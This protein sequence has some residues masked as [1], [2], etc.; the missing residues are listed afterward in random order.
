MSG[1]LEDNLEGGLE[2][3]DLLLPPIDESDFF[4]EE[5]VKE[6]WAGA[7][8]R[9]AVPAGGAPAAG[10]ARGAPVDLDGGDSDGPDVDLDVDLDDL[11]GD[12]DGAEDD[13][14][15]SPGGEGGK[16]R[17]P[18]RGNKSGI[19]TKGASS[20]AD[21]KRMRRKQI[22]SA[23]RASRARR[24]QELEDLREENKKLRAERA[25]FLN[26]IG[27]LQVKVENMRERGSSDMRVENALLRAQLEEHKRFVSHF[28]HLCDGAPSTAAGRH[29]IYKQGSDAAQ[30]HVLS[31]L[32]QSCADAWAAGRVGANV[33]VPFQNF[34]FCYKFKSEYGDKGKR[35][36][37][38][39]VDVTFPGFQ[40]SSVSDF[41]WSSFSSADIQQRLY[42]VSNIELTQLADDM[43]DKD[44][45][46]VYFREKLE[47]PKKDQDWA[48]ICNRNAKVLPR[49]ALNLPPSQGGPALEPDADAD[50][51]AGAG[52][53]AALRPPPPPPDLRAPV[54]SSSSVGAFFSS[55]V[56]QAK[57]QKVA[58]A[59]PEASKV[60]TTVLALSTTQHSQFDNANRISSM[61]VQGAVTWDHGG[62]ARLI[63]VFSFPEDF[64]LKAME[65]FHDVISQDGSIGVKFAEVLNEFNE[66]LGEQ[67]AEL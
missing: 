43:P 64:K 46:L 31:L 26:K 61:F 30:A 52:A 38:V 25:S 3:F 58:A 6:E 16:K 63:I 37:N 5:A 40:A 19:S 27:E 55:L 51:G 2:D 60:A 8:L 17:A 47:A 18:A 9:V 66:M 11:D 15:Q 28:K 56:P 57:R 20:E 22:A 50:A 41:M 39:R 33:R 49:H 32:S 4:S 21:K 14:A 12:D 24:K 7:G 48:V 62:D 34:S 35:R 59:A 36:L 54:S 13:D 67:G 23:S 44:T 10:S 53:D 45:K 65:G 42:R 29:V 1:F